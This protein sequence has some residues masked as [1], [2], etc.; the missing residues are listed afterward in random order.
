MKGD[1]ILSKISNTEIILERVSDAF[2]SLNRDLKIEYINNVT[3]RL[4]QIKREN[5]VGQYIFDALPHKDLKKFVTR[6]KRALTEQEPIEF[7]EYFNNRWYEIRAF[8]SAEGLSVFFRDIT[9]Q[10][11]EMF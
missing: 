6:Y 3:E 1:K 5:V 8:P 11:Q 10:K 4:L 9:E 2:Y 7:E